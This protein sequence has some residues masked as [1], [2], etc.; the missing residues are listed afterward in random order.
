MQ[1]IIEALEEHNEELREEAFAPF[2]VSDKAFKVLNRK[3]VKTALGNPIR[4]YDQLMF[5]FLGYKTAEVNEL[6]LVE[7]LYHM[8]SIIF[9]EDEIEQIA[10]ILLFMNKDRNSQPPLYE[11]VVVN[12]AKISIYDRGKH[13]IDC[14]HDDYCEF[15]GDVNNPHSI[16]Y[17]NFILNG[18]TESD[19]GREDGVG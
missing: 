16:Y 7:H 11:R 3:K 9:K 15:L 19:D 6:G 2:F 10:G 4:L 12:E 14:I 17:L 5:S 18:G 1:D 13:I 8:N